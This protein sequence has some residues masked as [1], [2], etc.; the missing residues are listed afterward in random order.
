METKA[1][2]FLVR[3]L[4][5]SPGL[6]WEYS[7]HC[8]RWNTRV[9]LYSAVCPECCGSNSCLCDGWILWDAFWVG[10]TFY[11]SAVFQNKVILMCQLQHVP[12][13]SAGDLRS[14]GF[15]G[16][17]P[18]LPKE[19]AKAVLFVTAVELLLAVQFCSLR[20]MNH[21][22]TVRILLCAEAGEAP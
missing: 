22:V 2:E 16:F 4:F 1:L 9:S 10:G 13:V 21:S 20:H 18:L 6:R 8:G 14:S 17:A 11:L 15:T 7:V 12:V 19:H 3:S 5:L